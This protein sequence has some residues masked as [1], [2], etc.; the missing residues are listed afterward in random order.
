MTRTI[1][2]IDGIDGSGKSM[3]ARRLAAALDDAGCRTVVVSVDDF[4]RPVDWSAASPTEAEV[5][6]DRYYDLA[7]AEECL[8]AFVAGVPRMIIPVFDSKRE[9]IV[10][11]RSLVFDGAA[12]AIVEGVFPLRIPSAASGF[13]IY[14]DATPA[15]ARRR[16][17]ERDVEKG[18]TREDIEHRIDRRYFPGQERYRSAIDPR[19][20]AHVIIDNED[21]AAPRALRRDLAAVPEPLRAL[22]DR[23]L[24]Q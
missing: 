1:V 10:E 20:R 14:L 2:T 23:L 9:T 8:R 17:I 16:I 6:Y 11:S 5:Y 13:S 19:G 22:L 4:R 18:R 3:F 12:A 15:L 24:P 21:P 7:L